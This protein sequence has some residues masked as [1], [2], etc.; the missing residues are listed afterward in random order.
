MNP[1]AYAADVTVTPHA[2][3]ADVHLTPHAYAA[4][5]DLPP[6]AYAADMETARY[7]HLMHIQ[8]IWALLDLTSNAHSADVT[9]NTDE[10]SR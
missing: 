2:Y 10:L 8:P 9:E 1:H 6:D 4:N 5:V 3:S 7:E